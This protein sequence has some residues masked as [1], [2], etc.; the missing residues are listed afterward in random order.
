MSVM[1]SQDLKGYARLLNGLQMFRIKE[2]E[3]IQRFTELD[4][5]RAKQ[6]YILYT[7]NVKSF[8]NRYK[9]HKAEQWYTEDQFLKTILH[10]RDVEEYKTV[11][12]VLKSL[13]FL[14]YQIEETEFK[15]SYGES[16]AIKWLDAYITDCQSYLLRKYTQYEQAEWRL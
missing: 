1:L 15:L 8:N 4:E 5:E 14:R 11:E 3:F 12:Q 2:M 7:L 10:D 16:N 9:N 13:Q 6:L